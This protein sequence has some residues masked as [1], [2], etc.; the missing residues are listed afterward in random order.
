MQDIPIVS[1]YTVKTYEKEN[2]CRYCAELTF[3]DITVLLSNTYL[4]LV[5]LGKYPSVTFTM[6]NWI[7]HT[8]SS[9]FIYRDKPIRNTVFYFFCSTFTP[10]FFPSPSRPFCRVL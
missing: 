4:A 10:L 2:V 9:A 7:W 5:G 1:E 6:D 3:V 8:H